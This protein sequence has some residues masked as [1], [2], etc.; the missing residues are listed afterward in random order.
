MKHQGKIIIF[1]N[2][3]DIAHTTRHIGQYVEHH[4]INKRYNL[5]CWEYEQGENGLQVVYY[6]DEANGH[7]SPNR[8]NTMALINRVLSE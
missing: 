6:N 7:S 8:K 2:T 1:Q 3:Y 5:D 4:N